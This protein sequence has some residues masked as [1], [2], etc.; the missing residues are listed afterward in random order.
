MDELTAEQQ[1]DIQAQ[2]AKNE[3]ARAEREKLAAERKAKREAEAAERKEK[4]EAEKAAKEQ[5][6]ANKK[7]EREQKEADAKAAREA[8]RAAREAAKTEG[9]GSTK[10]VVNQDRYQYEA[11][12]VKTASGRKS[13]DC[14]DA[15]SVA[16]RGKTAD[17]VVALVSENGLEVSEN[18]AKLNPGLRRMSASNVL[19]R[20]ARGENGIMVDGENVKLSKAA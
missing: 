7:A 16:L 9:D 12:G 4:R 10:S 8:A 1:A 14:G 5:A 2:K 13:V 6:R 17:E 18:W 20:A 15:V 3:A 11:N 19:R